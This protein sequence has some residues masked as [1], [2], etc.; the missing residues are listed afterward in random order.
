M[1]KY[2][3]KITKNY[4]GDITKNVKKLYPKPEKKELADWTE[5][6]EHT[7]W[8][9]L[10]QIRRKRIAAELKFSQTKERQDFYEVE[11][12]TEQQNILLFEGVNTLQTN[13]NIKGKKQPRKRPLTIK[14]P[15]PVLEQKIIDP[16]DL[17]E[18][19]DDEDYKPDQNKNDEQQD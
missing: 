8:E 12:L 4:Y 1:P 17:S 9:I 5:D 6:K 15:K 14:I 2:Q 7:N 18:T 19:T 3:N 16:I 11:K 10:T 13:N